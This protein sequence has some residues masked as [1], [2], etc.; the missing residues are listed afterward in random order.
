MDQSDTGIV[1]WKIYLKYQEC[2]C[3]I[4]SY[5]PGLKITPSAIVKI[6]IRRIEKFHTSVLFFSLHLVISFS[7][8]W[9]HSYVQTCTT[10]LK[11]QLRIQERHAPW[12]KSCHSTNT[13]TQTH[14]ARHSCRCNWG[15]P[16]SRR[17]LGIIDSD[18]TKAPYI[19]TF[20]I[21]FS[22]ASQNLS[23]T[24]KA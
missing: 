9:Q 21:S 4:L 7:S 14:N 6:D 1:T 12:E 10:Y 19:W 13:Q 20:G 22:C 24:N 5:L 2:S 16:C 3:L 11:M 23:W 8:R 15:T 18:P 17:N